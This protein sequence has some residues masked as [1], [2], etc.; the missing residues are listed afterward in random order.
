MEK[1]HRIRFK[2][3]IAGLAKIK[4]AR[5]EKGWN[6]NNPLWLQEASKVLGVVSSEKLAPGVSYGTWKRFLGGKKSVNG[7]AFKAYCR[8]LDLD[9]QQVVED[10]GNLI[11]KRQDWGE[12][13]DVSF[14]LG[15]GNELATISNWL[16]SDKC[17][18]V[19]L[20]GMG[21]IGKTALSIKIARSLRDEYDR[22]I[23]RSLRNAPPLSELLSDLIQFISDRQETKLPDS[24]ELKINLLLKYLTSS[25]CLLI[26]DNVESILETTNEENSSS[27]SDREYN[28]LFESVG[29][30]NHQSCLL[31]TSREKPS[32]ITSLEQNNTWVR[33]LQL[34]GLSIA[35]AQKILALKGVFFGSKNE[36]QQLINRYGGNPLALK[37]VA[38]TIQDFFAGDITAFLEFLQQDLFICD[39]I[40]LLL[41]QQ[42][43]R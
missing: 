5:K 15:R 11:L 4:Q 3:S 43:E 23:W 34:T 42:F 37:I 38:S 26:L 1:Q 33:S 17:S 16:V 29:D 12:A 30:A 41:Q 19:L 35:E 21:G 18:L 39:D 2:A 20:L 36:W 13:I 27:Q 10:N 24:I 25:R 7:N 31:L 6:L 14:F 28:R 40:Y 32:A 8:I 9:W 22:V